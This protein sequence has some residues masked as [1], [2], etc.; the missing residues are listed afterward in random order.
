MALLDM[1]EAKINDRL[2]FNPR[3]SSARNSPVA[4]VSGTITRITT[5][6]GRITGPDRKV[7]TSWQ[8]VRVVPDAGL[9]FSPTTYWTVDLVPGN[10]F[11]LLP[12]KAVLATD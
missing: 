11:K 5:M 7:V 4:C 10:K 1:N 9:G 6:R 2:F 3:G 12:S 8:R